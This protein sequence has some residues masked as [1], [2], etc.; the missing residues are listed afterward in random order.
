MSDII[1]TTYR[2]DKIFSQKL[3][4]V[5]SCYDTDSRVSSMHTEGGDLRNNVRQKD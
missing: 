1:K 4:F 5:M 3:R 2:S